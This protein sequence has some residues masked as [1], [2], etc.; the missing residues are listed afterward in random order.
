MIEQ[1]VRDWSLSE[2][3]PNRIEVFGSGKDG[4]RVENPHLH[5]LNVPRRDHIANLPKRP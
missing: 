5:L 4:I 1:L 2:N 3:V